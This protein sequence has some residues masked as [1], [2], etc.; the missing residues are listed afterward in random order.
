[1]CDSQ[2]TRREVLI[3]A[4]LAASALA[5]AGALVG[6]DL[7]DAEAA[8]PAV[9]AVQVLP[10]LSIYPRDAWGADLPPK[11]PIVGETAK[12][13]LVHHTASPNNYP[14]AR[15]LIRTTYFW[16]TSNDPSKGW[17]DVAYEFFIGRDGDVW[18]GRKGALAGPV[19][20]D[21]TG[22]NQGFS[23]LVCL[24]GDF[25]SVQPTPA[26]KA[27][28]VKVLAWLADR[29]RIPTAA[30]STT[31]FVSRG[32]QRWAKGVTVTTP[33]IAPHRTMSYTGCPGDAF[34]ASTFA[35]P[36]G[37]AALCASVEAQRSAWANVMKPAVRLGRVTP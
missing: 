19:R 3:N 1:M 14:S 30:G 24:L 33:T 15:S 35:S 18:E 25:T 16:H 17:P 22:G 32:S 21:A 20:A 7:G 13:L 37:F 29:H 34:H 12:Y 2:P 6:R 10:G 31:S 28:L 26:A 9:P 8:G 11:G 4:G 36:S 5:V 27:S 23:Q